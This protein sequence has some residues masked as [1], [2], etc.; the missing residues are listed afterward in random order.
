MNQGSDAH[1]F[2]LTQESSGTANEKLF[3]RSGVHNL[4]RVDVKGQVFYYVD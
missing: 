1:G 2:F 4:G 3:F